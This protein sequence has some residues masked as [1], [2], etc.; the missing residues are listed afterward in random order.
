LLGSVAI[1]AVFFAVKLLSGGVSL[2]GLQAA[3]KT[4]KKR[5]GGKASLPKVR[6]TYSLPVALATT[7]TLLWF[8]R[9][10]LQLA[11]PKEARD[12]VESNAH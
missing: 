10:D 6:M 8:Y 3:L 2:Q 1:L 12:K 11:A 7:A 9:V 4:K 5:N